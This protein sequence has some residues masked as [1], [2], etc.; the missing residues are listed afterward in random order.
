MEPPPRHAP[1]PPERAAS[2]TLLGS[3]T[4]VGER[5]QRVADIEFDDL[6]LWIRGDR[7]IHELLPVWEANPPMQLG[8]LPFA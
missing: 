3:A 8:R 4:R 5:Q 2:P 7:R 6:Q 1:S